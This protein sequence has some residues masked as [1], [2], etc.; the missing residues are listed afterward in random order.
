MGTNCKLFDGKKL[1]DLD[2]FHHFGTAVKSGQKFTKSEIM[3][4]LD[5]LLADESPQYDGEDADRAARRRHWV[6]A[7]R[8]FA[9]ASESDK[10]SFCADYDRDYLP[11][12]LQ[13]GLAA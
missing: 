3:E 8:D 9:D 10:F 13:F 12:H 2:R 5:Q 4:F 6:K 7:A 11:D 1:C